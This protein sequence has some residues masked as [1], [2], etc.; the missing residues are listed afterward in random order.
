MRPHFQRDKR[1]HGSIVYGCVTR[2]ATDKPEAAG[3]VL[4]NSGQSGKHAHFSD[5]FCSL[6]M[7]I[8]YHI[9]H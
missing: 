3:L 2:S 9:G 5:M 8:T 4:C 6:S 1:R 7:I